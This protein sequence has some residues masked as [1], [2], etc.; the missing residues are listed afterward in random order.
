MI[1]PKLPVEGLQNQE[2]NE[3]QPEKAKMN[4]EPPIELLKKN[5]KLPSTIKLIGILT[6]KSFDIFRKQTKKADAAQQPAPAPLIRIKYMQD[7]HS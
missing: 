7:M 6:D 2:G 4:A 1:V 5:M 3:S